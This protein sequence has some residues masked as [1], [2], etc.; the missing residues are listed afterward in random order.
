MNHFTLSLATG[1][2]AGAVAV[3]PMVA[4]KASVRTCCV[5]V[6]ASHPAG[7]LGC[8]GDLPSRPGWADGMGVALMLT[9]PSATIGSGKENRLIPMLLNAVLL[10]FLISVAEHYLG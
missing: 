3:L 10:G 6:P 4:R 2:I 8:Y 5:G 1:A 9:I 7:V